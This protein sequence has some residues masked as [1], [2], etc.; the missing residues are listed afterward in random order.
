MDQPAPADLAWHQL[1]GRRRSELRR[2]RLLALALLLAMAAAFVACSILEAEWPW[3]A[4][5][6]AFAEAAMVGACADWFAVVALFRRPFGLPIPHTA[7]VPRHKMRIGDSL[8]Q[9]ISNNFLS[10]APLSARLESVD[11]AGWASRW[12]RQPAN[13]ALAANR[14]RAAL[15]PLFGLLGQ[16]RIRRAGRRLIRRGLDRVAAA[17]L[18]ARGLAALVAH[19]GHDLLFDRLIDI[20]EFFFA[21][22]RD[23]I[24]RRVVETSP[25]W[26]PAWVDGKVTD[27]F[28]A[29]LEQTLGAARGQGHPWRE[30]FRG[31][32]LGLSARLDHD[33]AMAAWCERI[34]GEFLDDGLIETCLDLLGGEVAAAIRHG[35]PSAGLDRALVALGGWLESDSHLRALVNAGA[36]ELVLNAVVPNRAEIGSFV[37]EVVTRW[38]TATLVDKLELQV[39]KDLQ[40][41][42]INGTLVGGLVGLAIFTVDRLLR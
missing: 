29:E 2:M 13:A 19:G 27:A 12:L 10:P 37:T 21:A 38:D 6:R 34:K 25:R 7:I 22:H 36:R 28:L 3:L 1:T 31:A 24:R 16:E 33:P 32:L 18:A 39:G 17:A 8:G 5:P 26:L 9:F 14:L 35:P 4:Y 30:R 23:D 41:I 15:P 40:Y 20:A 11:A 42:R